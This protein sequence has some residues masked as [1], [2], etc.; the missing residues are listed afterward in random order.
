MSDARPR[1]EPIPPRDDQESVWDYPRPPRV[2]PAH[3]QVEVIY[4][5]N[6][7][8]LTFDALRVVETS[9]PPVYYLPADGVITDYLTAS[10]RT[11][12]CE[13]KGMARYY[14]VTVGRHS[15]AH[16]AWSYP[17]P[18]PGYEALAGYY[19]F[20]A[21]AMEACLV[22]GELVLPQPGD[23]YGGWI[24]SKVVGPFK[25]EPGTDAW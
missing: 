2:L 13:Y 16:A 11:S 23:F 21:S 18:R 9:H 19:A 17:E 6:T 1:P 8:A 14:T 20:Y 24:T 5:G 15:A 7:I 12:W 3:G 22:G 25:G 4:G 10:G